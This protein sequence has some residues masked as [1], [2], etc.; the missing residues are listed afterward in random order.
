MAFTEALRI[1]I[2]ADTRGAVRGI[3]QVGA[4]TDKSLGKSQKNLDK[5]GRGLTVAG[6]GMVALGGAALFGLGKAAMASE[7]AN[8]S[9]VKLENTL[10]NMPR[11]AGENSKSFID[12]ANAIQDKTAA[13]ADQIVEA[14]ALLGTFQLTGDEIRKITPLVVDYARKFG[15]DMTDAAKQ[16]GKALDGQIGALRRSGVSIDENLFKTDRYA[17]V[18][19]ALRDQ[20]G[21]FAEEEGKTFAGSL[22]RLKNQLGDVAE[23][24]GVGAVDAFSSLFGVIDGGLDKV[25]ELS[26]ATQAVIGKVATFGSIAL[27]A[28]GGLSFLV[29]QALTARSRFKELGEVLGGLRPKLAALAGPAGL[30]GV[31][32]ALV[33]AGAG[34]ALYLR[35]QNEEKI[36]AGAEAFA[37]LEGSSKKAAAATGLFNDAVKVS[38]IDFTAS[39]SA[40]D[41]LAESGK[42]TAQA[43]ED[44]D[45]GFAQLLEKAPHLAE[46]FIRSAEAKGVDADAIARWRE[47]LQGKIQADGEA[48]ASQE[49]YNAQVDEAAGIT[50]E[51]TSALQEYSDTLKAM[52][53]PL[54]GAMDAI[55]GVRDAQLAEKD[56]V[57][58]VME[59]NA[60]LNEAR[61]SGNED[62]IAEATRNLEDAQRNLSDAQWATVES[63]AQA[64]AALAGLKDAVDR[65]DVSVN[66][67]RDTLA[68]WVR[69]GFLTQDQADRAA[70]SVGGLAAEAEDADKKRVDIPVATP[71]AD[72]SRER[73]RRVKDAVGMIPNRKHI[74]VTARD[75]ASG[76][77]RGVISALDRIPSLTTT[78]IQ[79]QLR[80]SISGGPQVRQHGG[81]VRKGEAYIVG[82]Q[83]PEVFVPDR[84]GMILPS[85]QSLGHMGSAGGGYVDNRTINITTG[86]DP[87]QVVA[88]LRRAGDMGLPITIRGRSL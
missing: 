52:I 66:E 70:K 54:F 31:A 86:A 28:A 9:V 14:E 22:E 43:M 75:R 50:E 10:Q 36:L 44:L 80:G 56:A 88:A 8:L 41:T 68:T 81:P 46:E 40:A 71:G 33:A 3:E 69:Q 32:A 1:L 45:S 25:K 34:I 15:V 59:A 30:A 82:E 39:A 20:V 11:L 17:A 62:E 16:V 55:T 27:I 60:A 35:E 18:T 23:G 12:L 63:A 83:R 49:E 13:D 26:P 5:L 47:Q 6:A 2:D 24:V 58:A 29:G 42:F 37:K 67:F 19:Q 77:I 78:V 57:A 84:N 21:G 7:E 53:D 73:L 48:I 85:V 74:D 87:Q 76:V 72:D 65:G 38:T 64:D 51:A 4:A 61:A 79:A